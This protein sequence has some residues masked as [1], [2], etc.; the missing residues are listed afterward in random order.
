MKVYLEYYLAYAAG[1]TLFPMALALLESK[2]DPNMPLKS[3]DI[4][5]LRKVM[6]F[7]HEKHVAN[8]RELLLE[9]GANESDDDRKRWELRK[10]PDNTERISLPGSL[11]P[12]LPV[13]VAPREPRLPR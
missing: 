10:N 5:P 4:S 9:F 8:M 2:A 7:A 3:G 11:V 13:F 6:C 12:D 1:S